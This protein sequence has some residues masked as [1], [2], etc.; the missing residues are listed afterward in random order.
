[1]KL[2]GVMLNKH[3]GSTDDGV[4]SDMSSENCRVKMHFLS[5]LEHLKMLKE[6]TFDDQRPVSVSCVKLE[7]R[8]SNGV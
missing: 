8:D 2:N 5:R 3:G 1:M 7:N 6:S 4:R